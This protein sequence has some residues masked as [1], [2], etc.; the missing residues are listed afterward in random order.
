MLD[1]FRSGDGDRGALLRTRPAAATVAICLVGGV[2][3]LAAGL[4]GAVVAIQATGEVLHP[5]RGDRAAAWSGLATGMTLCVLG[6]GAGLGFLGAAVP[7]EVVRDPGTGDLLVRRHPLRDQRIAASR[8]RCVRLLGTS[9]R[10]GRPV[11]LAWVVA[12]RRR[13]PLLRDGGRDLGAV[14]ERV[15][16]HVARLADSLGV[17][18]E[19]AGWAA[20]P[21]SVPGRVPGRDPGRDPG[22]V[23]GRNGGEPPRAID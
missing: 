11:I 4:A 13:V 17:P 5:G 14:L 7:H 2:L 15:A 10:S 18:V 6:G 20:D 21:G 19:R 9:D 23:P 1:W 12:G 16:P 3:A 22:R 8:L